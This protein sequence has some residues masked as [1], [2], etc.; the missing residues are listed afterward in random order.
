M[1]GEQRAACD[2]RWEVL[3]RRWIVEGGT[4]TVDGGWWTADGGRRKEEIGSAV[5]SRWCRSRGFKESTSDEKMDSLVSL[6]C[7][8]PD[9]AAQQPAREEEDQL[10]VSA[11]APIQLPPAATV[12]VRDGGPRAGPEWGMGDQDRA[13]SRVPT[14]HRRPDFQGGPT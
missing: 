9:C 14:A 6:A 12:G 11:T 7:Q 4:W 2:R 1:A 13:C 5:F 8:T 10:I 3:A